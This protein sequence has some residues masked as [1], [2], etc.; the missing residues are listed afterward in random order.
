MK[1]GL[2]G[3]Y[4]K[5]IGPIANCNR[6]KAHLFKTK[7][8]WSKV[9]VD[10]VVAVYPSGIGTS[11]KPPGDSQTI[12]DEVLDF[13]YGASKS[14]KRICI[15]EELGTPQDY[16]LT[17]ITEDIKLYHDVKVIHNYGY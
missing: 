8:D 14:L 4:N 16:I 6:W 1:I 17:A 7:F 3:G 2:Y 10:D 15:S 12:R 5:R 13:I 11:V 9:T